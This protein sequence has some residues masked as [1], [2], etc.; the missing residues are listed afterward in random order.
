MRGRRRRGRRREEKGGGE[1]RTK[2]GWIHV[3]GF[4]KMPSSRH[5]PLSPPTSSLRTRSQHPQPQGPSFPFHLS[6][7]TEREL[8]KL[9]TPPH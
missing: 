6:R 8:P 5:G 4:N 3:R 1:R 7:G 2:E 9:G